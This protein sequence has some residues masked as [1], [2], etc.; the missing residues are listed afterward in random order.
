MERERIT[1]SIK[2]KIL[3]KVDAEIDGT[4][5][6]NRS[7]AIETFVTKGIGYS[8]EKNAVIL[9]GGD[10]ALKSIPATRVYLKKLKESGFDKIVIAV[11]FLGDKVKEKLGSG[12]EF[13]LQIQYTDK[14]EGSGGAI[15]TL[16]KSFKNTFLVFN[17]GKVYDID[18]NTCLEYHKNRRVVAT[19]LTNDLNTME[20]IYILEPETFALIPRGFSM[21]E[22]EILPKLIKA[23][24]I[25]VLP[26]VH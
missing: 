16:K 25:A 12:E 4:N 19:V 10:N 1:I 20:G 13:G 24:K 11:G 5:I 23:G 8:P 18:L 3:E 9:L 7:H 17:I 15:S 6:R 14:G 2:K 22:D 26:Q 21:L